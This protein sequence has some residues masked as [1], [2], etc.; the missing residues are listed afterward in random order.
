MDSI[1][2]Q[3]QDSAVVDGDVLGRLGFA[4]SSETGTNARLVVAKIEAV[5]EET[6]DAS[7]NATEMVFYLAPDGAASAKMTLGSNGNLAVLGQMNATTIAINST[8]IA[9][10]AADIN[11]VCSPDTTIGTRTVD[12]DDGIPHHDGAG[13]YVTDVDKFDDYFSATTKTLTN[14]TLTSPDINTPDIDGGTIDNCVIGGNTAAAGTFTNIVI[15]DGGNIGSASDTD[16]I[17]ISS[18]GTVTFSQAHVGARV[19]KGNQNTGTVSLDASTSN[20]FE[21]NM[22]GDFQLDITNAVLGQRIIVRINQDDSVGG[23]SPFTLTY[24]D[25]IKWAGGS[26]PTL[27]EDKADVLGFLCT[28]ASSAFDGFVIGQNI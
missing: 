11:T 7:N 14:K 10:S 18:G 23:T 2:L 25:T 21:I 3:T 20:Y 1:I 8:A 6:F 15:G 19:D 5:A 4:A 17:A 24:A 12:G 16:A 26:A 28:T 13:V 27:T 9:A 22:Q